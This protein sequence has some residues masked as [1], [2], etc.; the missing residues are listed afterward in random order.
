MAQPRRG[1]GRCEAP[2][3]TDTA[4]IAALSP[5][6]EIVENISAL[7]IPGIEKLPP[8][9]RLAALMSAKLPAVRDMARMYHCRF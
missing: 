1:E 9:N 5:K 7:E 8:G 4:G 2:L 6:L 3:G